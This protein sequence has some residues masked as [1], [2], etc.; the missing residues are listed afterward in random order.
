M[1]NKIVCSKILVENR[2]IFNFAKL[3]LMLERRIEDIAKKPK[4]ESYQTLMKI[5]DKAFPLASAPL[6]R[7]L[8]MRILTKIDNIPE[9]HL[10][11]LVE[12]KLPRCTFSKILFDSFWIFYYLTRIYI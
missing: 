1:R 12:G 10:N 3:K 11:A 8:V 7:P 6:L 2:V 4:E 9:E 5:L